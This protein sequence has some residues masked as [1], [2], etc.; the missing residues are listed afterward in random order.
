MRP[1]EDDLIRGDHFH[2]TAR[3]SEE[4]GGKK[5]GKADD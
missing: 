3:E 1:I 5:Q 2:G 4:I